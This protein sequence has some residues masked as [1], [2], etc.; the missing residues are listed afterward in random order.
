MIQAVYVNFSHSI[1]KNLKNLNLKREELTEA[2]T[3]MA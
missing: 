2:I 1:A 3:I